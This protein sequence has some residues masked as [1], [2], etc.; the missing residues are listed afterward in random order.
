MNAEQNYREW[1]QRIARAAQ[2][3]Q[4]KA[5]RLSEFGLA[6]RGACAQYFLNG[7]CESQTSID[8]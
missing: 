6:M 5:D 7:R 8:V 3:V 1:M 2:L 4:D